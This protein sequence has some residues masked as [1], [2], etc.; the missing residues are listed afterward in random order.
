LIHIKALHRDIT[1]RRSH[2]DPGPGLDA[3]IAK[4]NAII[5]AAGVP[6][7]AAPPP[8]KAVVYAFKP[9]TV[10]AASAPVERQPP[11][12]DTSAAAARDAKRFVVGQS[13]VS[14]AGW[15]VQLGAFDIEREALQRLSSARAKVGHV[16]DHAQ[17]FTEAV[18][19]GEKTLYRARLAGFQQKEDAEAACKELKQND[20]D[21]MIIKN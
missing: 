15:I 6:A 7:A 12:T 5:P 21:C 9:A 1:V 10:P 20:F 2:Y 4:G 8:P 16:L 14:H 13:S 3:C 18:S 11:G 19:K 17:S